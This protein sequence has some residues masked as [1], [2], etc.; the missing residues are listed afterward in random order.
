MFFIERALA[1]LGRICADVLSKTPSATRLPDRQ[2]HGDKK[3]QAPAQRRSCE[4]GSPSSEPLEKNF[5]IPYFCKSK[6]TAPKPLTRVK[7]ILQANPF[8]DRRALFFVGESEMGF[9]LPV[10]DAEQSDLNR[11]PRYRSWGGLDRDLN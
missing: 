3:I 8:F 5:P 2:K 6:T 10:V 1:K 7:G 11:G 4:T 9:A